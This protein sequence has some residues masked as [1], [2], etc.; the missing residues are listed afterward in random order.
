MARGPDVLRAASATMACIAA[1][2]TAVA[3]GSDDSGNET[4]T[5]IPASSTAGAPS[6]S[7]PSLNSSTSEPPSTDTTRPGGIG[8]TGNVGSGPT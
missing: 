1:L 2:T 4:S 8:G 5:P 6:T 7:Q 3:C